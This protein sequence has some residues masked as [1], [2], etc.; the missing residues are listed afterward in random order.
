MS[1]IPSSELTDREI[2]LVLTLNELRDALG[3]T[4]D[5]LQSEL[6][7]NPPPDI[8]A[9]HDL[10][11]RRTPHDDI[12]TDPL[13]EFVA[14]TTAMAR[15]LNNASAM[16]AFEKEPPTAFLDWV[17]LATIESEPPGL[18]DRQLS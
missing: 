18:T 17:I 6:E 4:L 12:V 14:L 15:F 3:K 5:Y 11:S 10:V 9:F 7:P 13:R 8:V 1:P 16:E 2:E